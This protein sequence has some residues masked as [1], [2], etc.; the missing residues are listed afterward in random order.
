MRIKEVLANLMSFDCWSFKHYSL[1]KE[2][3]KVVINALEQCRW[4]DP[5]INEPPA[6]GDEILL[7]VSGVAENIT[8]EKATIVGFYEEGKY[9]PDSGIYYDSLIVHAWLPMPVYKEE[10]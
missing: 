6:N 3:A 10:Q 1:T 8:Y 7:C 2:E 5:K 9:Y 4:R